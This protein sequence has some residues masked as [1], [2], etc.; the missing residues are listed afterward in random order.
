MD[1]P[2]QQ[3]PT[4]ARELLAWTVDIRRGRLPAAEQGDVHYP[5]EYYF[6]KKN[7]NGISF[8]FC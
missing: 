5:C 3:A 8:S 2:V 4:A 1:I 6:S 7:E